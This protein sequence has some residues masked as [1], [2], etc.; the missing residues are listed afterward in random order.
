MSVG[1]YIIGLVIKAQNDWRVS[2]GR[3]LQCIANAVTIVIVSL[4]Q[5]LVA[6]CFLYVQQYCNRGVVRRGH[7]GRHTPLFT[8]GDGVPL[9]VADA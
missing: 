3:K 5:T 6:Q 4:T 9:Y 8:R 7:E 1:W 2:G